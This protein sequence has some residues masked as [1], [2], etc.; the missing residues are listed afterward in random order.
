MALLDTGKNMMM[1]PDS[2]SARFDSPGPAWV[3]NNSK[4]DWV[5]PPQPSDPTMDYAWDD[6]RGWVGTPKPPTGPTG[7]AIGG[8]GGTGGVGAKVY[9]AT[10]GT[11]FTDALAYATYQAACL[12]YT[13]PSPRDRTRSRMPSSA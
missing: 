1:G 10:D 5:Q 11:T 7:G 9:T 12:L 2:T 8:T 4:G 13:S 6:T 3:W